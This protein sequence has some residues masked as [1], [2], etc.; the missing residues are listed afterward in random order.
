MRIANSTEDATSGAD[1]NKPHAGEYAMDSQGQFVKVIKR[2]ASQ[3]ENP[4]LDCS[5]EDEK[6]NEEGRNSGR[7]ADA[8]YNAKAKSKKSSMPQ[9]MEG[10]R[11]VALV[12]NS[13]YVH[14]N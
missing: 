6:Y 12:G 7:D 13:D 10:K 11:M 2:N 9:S 5:E 8:S 14:E 4:L 1:V 3:L